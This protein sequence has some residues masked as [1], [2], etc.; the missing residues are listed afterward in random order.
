MTTHRHTINRWSTSSSK[1]SRKKY[2]CKAFGVDSSFGYLSLTAPS[3]API[4]IKLV[5]FKCLNVCIHLNRIACDIFG[6]AVSGTVGGGGRFRI[7]DHHD[8]IVEVKSIGLVPNK[9]SKQC[10]FWLTPFP[11]T[12]DIC[13]FKI[14]AEREMHQFDL[15]KLFGRSTLWSIFHWR[16]TSD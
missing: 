15:I 12:H 14:V 11:L 9:N 2:G 8:G 7:N 4:K 6:L 16:R 1:K 3:L 13:A 10:L 5:I